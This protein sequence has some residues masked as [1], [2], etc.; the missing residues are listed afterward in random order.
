MNDRS[1]KY[2]FLFI[3]GDVF[4]AISILLSKIAIANLMQPAPFIPNEIEGTLIVVDQQS[5]EFILDL[6]KQLR[7]F[8]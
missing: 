4:A 1:N 7:H 2:I 8:V 5:D 6:L 3:A